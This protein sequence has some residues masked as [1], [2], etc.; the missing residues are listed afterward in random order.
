M[1]AY[2]TNGGRRNGHPG[3]KLLDVAEDGSF[4]G[5]VLQAFEPVPGR[6]RLRF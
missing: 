1:V 5:K 4:G 6:A 3:T 2:E